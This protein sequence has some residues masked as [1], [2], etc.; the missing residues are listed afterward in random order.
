[1]MGFSLPFSTCYRGINFHN[2][3]SACGRIISCK[4]MS[5]PW[6]QMVTKIAV[7]KW[8]SQPVQSR[9]PFLIG[10]M[11]TFDVDH[12][13]SFFDYGFQT[14]Y[15]VIHVLLSTHAEEM[16]LFMITDDKNMKRSLY[17]RSWGY[18]VQ[19]S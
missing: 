9:V 11:H 18:I 13:H 1:M 17:W 8:D 19:W 15:A 2:R 6:E 3:G 7:M 12:H 16:N 14:T 5:L 10:G 4:G